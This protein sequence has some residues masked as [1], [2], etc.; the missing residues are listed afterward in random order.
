MRVAG[1]MKTVLGLLAVLVL[2]MSAMSAILAV[3]SVPAGAASPAGHWRGQTYDCTGGNVPP[4]NYSSMIITGV[5]YAPAGT[6][7]IWGDLNVAPGALFDAVTPGD[8]AGNP[9]LPATVLVGG[10]VN[11]GSGAVLVLGCSPSQ[12][13]HAITSDYIGGNL[14]GYG[15][16]GIVLHAVSIRGSASV[17]GGGGGAAGGAA[18]GGCFTSPIP[19]P[20]SDDAALSTG[21]NGTPQFTDFEDNSIGGNLSIVGVQT[22]WLGSFRNQVGGSVTLNGNSTSDP[23]GME[24]AS[25]MVR[26]SLTCLS[27]VP[28]VQFG[29]SSGASNT[30]GGNGFG[31]CGF[32]VVLP[33][34]APQANEGTGVP[35][36]I[37]VSSW[38]LGTYYG[39]HT[40]V[41][42]STAVPLGSPFVTE[43]GNTLAA[44]LNNVVLGGSG[45]T[46]SITVVPGSMLGSTGEVVVASVHPDGSESF[47]AVDNCTCSF[48]GKTG[49]V[50]VW[51]YGTTSAQG[52]TYGTF[53][54][55]SGGA[56]IGGGLDT[57]A[58][59]GSFSSW[60]EPAGTLSLVEH[61][62]L[63]GS[64]PRPPCRGGYHHTPWTHSFHRH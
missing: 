12:G 10:N 20:W 19:A 18:S 34:P 49:P 38:S 33:N 47:E 1:F 29:D 8:P 4:G 54:V 16:L 39:T 61:L 28:A 22:C 58:G 56:T 13:C 11:V 50:T 7:N 15:A 23:D 40:Q 17:Y 35:E 21:P 31:E 5:C 57:L 45:L 25:N 41:G 42:A 55:T 44:E 43:S 51:A 6:I 48:Q 2:A 14:T 63:N 3:G 32:N 62:G 27:N 46:G 64:G 24:L 53:L 60:G 59:Y 9:L 26:G 30:V 36:H 37:A 52:V